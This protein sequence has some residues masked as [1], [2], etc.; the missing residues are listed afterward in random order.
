MNPAW[1]VQ[2]ILAEPLRVA[3]I[4][5]TLDGLRER[6][7]E[8]GLTAELEN[9]LPSQL[10]G[11]QRRRLMIA[12]ALAVPG[13]RAI[14]LDE[15]FS[16]L[17]R[18]A[19]QELASLLRTIHLKRNI[20]LLLITHDLM[21]VSLLASRVLVMGDGFIVEELP[22]VTFHSEA[23]HPESRALIEAALA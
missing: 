14:L 1:T 18:E 5:V 11:G 22:A 4:P 7:E 23:R 10:S 19:S 13:L 3:G 16:G 21:A 17:H 2:A 9:R 20:T 6:L 8:V 12:R 15:P